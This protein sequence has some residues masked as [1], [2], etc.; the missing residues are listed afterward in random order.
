MNNQDYVLRHLAGIFHTGVF[1]LCGNHLISYEES[2]EYNP[3]YNIEALR[4]KMIG[5]SDLQ[6]AP[7]VLRDEFHMFYICVKDKVVTENASAGSDERMLQPVETQASVC[8]SDKLYSRNLLRRTLS[9]TYEVRSRKR[10]EL[11]VSYSTRTPGQFFLTG[12]SFSY[13]M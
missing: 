1:G 9:L 13:R 4:L 8:A 6:S 3:L 2:P 5:A 12:G 7:L 11:L 10:G